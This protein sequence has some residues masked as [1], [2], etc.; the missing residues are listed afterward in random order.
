M[1]LIG[2]GIVTEEDEV[3]E[4]EIALQEAMDAI[5]TCSSDITILDDCQVLELQAN[6]EKT[7]GE[8]EFYKKRLVETE[9]KL[10][11][12]RDD[13]EKLTMKLEKAEVEAIESAVQINTLTGKLVI[14]T[15]G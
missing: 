3:L 13:V 6:L 2:S 10:R 4:P 12:S 9:E 15:C 7:K 8:I 1:A 5:S 14:K 11:A